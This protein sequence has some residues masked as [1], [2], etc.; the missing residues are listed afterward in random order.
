MFFLFF[1]CVEVGRAVIIYQRVINAGHSLAD[2]L[3]QRRGVEERDVTTGVMTV[4]E[5]HGILGL[6]PEMLEPYGIPSADIIVSSLLRTSVGPAVPVHRW[7]Y[8]RHFEG[9]RLPISSKISGANI[10]T[11]SR[12]FEVEPR[13]TDSP[14]EA[15]FADHLRARGGMLPGENALSIEVFYLYKPIFF[16]FFTW[17]EFYMTDLIIFVPRNTKFLFPPPLVSPV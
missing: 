9:E 15:V 12:R 10:E 17:T 14:V 1:A 8:Y 13:F 5:L 11:I 7:Q 4:R 6:F 3:T 2:M 16:S